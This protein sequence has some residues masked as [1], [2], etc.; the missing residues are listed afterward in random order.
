[1]RRWLLCA[2][3]CVLACEQVS[4]GGQRPHIESVEPWFWEVD[5]PPVE[6]LVISGHNFYLRVRTDQTTDNTIATSDLFRAT[7][8]DTTLAARWINNETLETP[9]PSLPIGLYSLT[10]TAPDGRHGELKDAIQVI[11]PG[12]T[13]GGNRREGPAAIRADERET[14]VAIDPVDPTS[15]IL[16]FNVTHTSHEPGTGLVTGWLADDGQSVTFARNTT[17]LY[18]TPAQLADEEMSIRWTVL[19]LTGIRVLRAQMILGPDLNSY[20]TLPETIDLARSFVIATHNLD[21]GHFA[22]NDWIRARLEDSQTLRLS[23]LQAAEFGVAAWQVV[24]LADGTVEHGDISLS[25]GAPSTTVT[26]LPPAAPGESMLLFSQNVHGSNNADAASALVSGRISNN[27]ELVFERFVGW[28]QATVDISWFRVTWPRMQVQ[29]GMTL[30][31]TGELGHDITLVDPVEPTR[32]V[33]LLAGQM[34]QSMADQAD[35]HV[36]AGWF[37]SEVKSAGKVLRLTRGVDDSTAHAYWQVIE[38]E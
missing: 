32:S 15:S 16:F 36:G 14:T 4:P 17:Q 11:E 34:R 31:D 33:S 23:L 28:T 27:T 8:G 1:M 26:G 18:D 38:F 29:R 6:P 13:P 24:E 3:V 20:V 19:Q 21:G 35:D 30:F 10:V 37:T 12:A 2:L 22:S 7:L 25:G 5:T 9:A